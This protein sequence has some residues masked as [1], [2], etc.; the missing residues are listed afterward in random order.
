MAP[1]F[2]RARND[3]PFLPSDVIYTI[4][5]LLDV[6]ERRA[7]LL[8]CSE[9]HYAVARVLY[10]SIY[11]HIEGPTRGSKYLN[12]YPFHILSSLVRS[13]HPKTGLPPR[14]NAQYMVTFAYL[15]YGPRADFR[16]APLLGEVLRAAVRLR[17]LR[18]E[19]ADSAVDIVLDALRRAQVIIVPSTTFT[20]RSAAEYQI[21]RMILPCLESVRST[22]LALVEA[23]MRYRNINTVVLDTVPN[24][25]TLG[26]FLRTLPP[27]NPATLRRLALS[28][29][30][31]EFKPFL[32][33]VFASFPGL[34]E[35]SF[36]IPSRGFPAL[37]FAT[38]SL[39][40]PDPIGNQSD[41]RLTG[42][43]IPSGGE[44]RVCPTSTDACSR[45]GRVV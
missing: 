26:I 28:Y 32:G 1:T 24:D 30:S 4:A 27:W 33:A 6:P 36:R 23:L 34:E 20:A 37:Q 38:V 16:A 18:L 39:M 40:H 12:H 3:G 44:G 11:V 5:C 15:S 41:I 8:S 19:V 21:D 9:Y 10:R 17:H 45:T 35:L 22:R 31:V 43:R 7:L 2:S 42:S 25:K 13:M 29:C 14:I